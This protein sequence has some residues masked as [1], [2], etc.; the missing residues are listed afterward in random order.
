MNGYRKGFTKDCYESGLYKTTT[1]RQIN[2]DIISN[3][4][5]KI[6]LTK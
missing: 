3:Y 6:R 2:K 4:L 1:S 5:F